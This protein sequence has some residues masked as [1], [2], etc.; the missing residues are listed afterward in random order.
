MENEFRED[1]SAERYATRGR[2][3]YGSV[4]AR[5]ARLA[6]WMLLPAFLIVFAVIVFPVLANFWIS[7]KQVRLGDLRPAVPSVR[8]F[9]A[10]VPSEPG[11]TLVLEYR[12]RNS[13]RNVPIHDVELAATIPPGLELD[14]TDRRCDVE[15]GRVRCYW[16]SWEG[17]YSDTLTFTFTA[18]EAYFDADIDERAPTE[19]DITGSSVNVLTTF[20]FTLDNFRFVFSA[21]RFWQVLRTT[22]V[23]PFMGTLGSIILGTTAA[24]L[25]NRK[26][27]GQGLLRGL[28]LFPYVA[29]IIAVTFTWVFILEPFRGTLNMYLMDLGFIEAPISF[30]SERYVQIRGE[31][32]PIPMALSMVILFDAW[33]YFPFSFLFILA[34]LQAIPSDL[35]ESVQVDGGGL[36]RQ[37]WSITLPQL[38]TVITTLFLLRFMWTFNK[39]DDV[40]LLTGGAAGTRTLPIQVYD[41]AFGRADI[42]A[43]SATAVVLFLFLAVFLLLYFRFVLKEEAE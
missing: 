22:F 26:F 40:F 20:D 19:A 34:R 38:Y 2:K 41:N 31:R 17:G 3:R 6:L 27:L 5:E 42:G 35:Y 36:V 30:L 7:A 13:S 10:E 32:T 1:E 15:D 16:E 25:L 23:Y 18:S 29:P 39:F 9:V 24:L 21:R 43:G 37:F 11:D 12:L 28:Y 8:E 4:T 14:S 33:R